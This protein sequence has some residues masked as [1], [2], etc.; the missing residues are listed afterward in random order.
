MNS[1]RRAELQRKLTLNAVP[2]PP[3]G[4][5]ERIKADIPKYLEAE[6]PASRFTRSLPFNLRIAASIVVLATSVVVA[7]MVM[8]DPERKMASES[9]A[10]PVIFAPAPR[11]IAA[12]DTTTTVAAVARTE[13]VSL[14]I[15]QEAPGIATLPTT[16]AP[17][18]IARLDDAANEGR[19]QAR[20]ESD[21]E[22]EASY[23][24][25]GGAA[26]GVVGGTAA[27]PPAEPQ[28]AELA[29]EPVPPP[30]D[31]QS[32]EEVAAAPAPA[33][34]VAQP[35]TVTAEAPAADA[36]R[37]RASAKLGAAAPAPSLVPAPAPVPPPPARDVVT[38][39]TAEAKKDSVFGISV[40]PQVFHDIRTTLESG[41]RPAAS[42]VN[43]EALVNYFAGAPARR[44]RNGVRLEVEAS[45][46]AIPAEGD[47]A[48]LRFTIDTPEGAGRAATDV[49]VDVV[50]SNDAVARVRR[51]G[52]QE[53]LAREAALPNGTSVTGL[54]ALE[55][56]PG[57]RQSQLVAT[58]RLHYVVNGKEETLT[59]HVHGRDLTKS[60]Q[61]A[62]RRHRLASLGALWG[63]SLKGTAAGGVDVARR[64]EELA[65]QEPDD[66]RARE[67][68]RAA[69]A[70]AA[71][72][73]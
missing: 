39:A 27:A 6:S 32:F 66:V 14:D 73:R 13:E 24:V 59:E 69:S 29:P 67:L 56:K 19:V 68:A 21:V 44:P 7:M 5:A 20:V 63:E 28:V 70:S 22:G 9:A 72:G 36:R 25:T 26:G 18:A 48:V 31:F 41:R 53:P 40:N 62:S 34:A 52:D 8:R 61:R 38:Q 50:I 54:Y 45:P 43:V 23:G 57:L 2:R 3:A 15:V 12:S 65:T 71:G 58:V 17:P 37:E 35:I 42:A 16:V 11:S 47:H 10:R 60:W 46:A 33:P 64:A 49:R 1:K 51:I 55:M 4:L 30:V